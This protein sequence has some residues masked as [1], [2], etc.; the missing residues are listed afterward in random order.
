MGVDHDL[1][2]FITIR[3]ESTAAQKNSEALILLASEKSGWRDLNS[4]PLEPHSKNEP[5]FFNAS[6]VL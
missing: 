1:S 3:S 5:L 6:S 4:R 2:R